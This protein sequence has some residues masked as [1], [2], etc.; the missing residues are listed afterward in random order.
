MCVCVFM[1][2]SALVRMHVYVCMPIYLCAY[3]RCCV[4]AQCVCPWM[5]AGVNTCGVC[6]Q[7]FTYQYL[8]LY[9]YC[10]IHVAATTSV[11]ST[12]CCLFPSCYTALAEYGCKPELLPPL[13][14]VPD[15]TML[16]S[17]VSNFYV[18]EVIQCVSPD[19]HCVLSAYNES[20]YLTQ[21]TS[22]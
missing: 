19:Q 6:V 22:I 2:V 8:K 9:I 15:T 4:C 17:A 1:C 20:N 12:S 10:I 7:V 3:V 21:Q 13:P 5:H 11:L 18:S 16:E 14:D